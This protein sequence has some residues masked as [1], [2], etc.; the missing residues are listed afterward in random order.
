[1]TKPAELIEAE[2]ID[3]VC[4]RYGCLPSALMDEDADYLLRTL[5]LVGLGKVE[6][7]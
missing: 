4:Q 6:T 3:G 1:M 7:E 2:L 5:A